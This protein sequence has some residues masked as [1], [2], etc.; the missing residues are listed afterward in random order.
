[1]PDDDAQPAA[2][3]ITGAVEDLSTESTGGDDGVTPEAASAHRRRIGLIIGAVVVTIGLVYLF[4][5]LTS[6][7]D[8]QRG[9]IIAGVEVGGL[10]PADAVTRLRAELTEL[11]DPIP[12]LSHG[13]PISLDPVASGLS[14]DIEAS[15]AA[16]GTRSAN[17]FSRVA[18]LFGGTTVEPL[19]A[20]VDEAALTARMQQIAATSDLE[21]VEGQL[22]LDGTTVRAVQPVTGEILDV[23]AAVAVISDRWTS[24]NPL[25][26]TGLTLPVTEQTVRVSA[27]AVTSSAAELSTL[28]AGPLTVAA[29]DASF[30]VPVESIATAITV[31]PD[32]A[33]GFTV[34]VDNDAIKALYRAQ[35][36]ATATPAID[37]S[38]SIVDNAPVITPGADGSAV[39]WATTDAALAAALRAPDHRLVVTYAPSRPAVTTEAVQALGITEVVSEFTTGGFAKDS[40]MNVRRAAEQLQGA[41][42]RPG[43]TFSLNGYTGV[44]NA[45]TGYVEAGIIDNGVAS[46]GIAGGVSQLATTLYNAGFFS[47][48]QDVEHKPHSFYISRYPPGRE[49]TVFT[50]DDGTSL[51]DVKFK[52]VYPTAILIQTRWT[53]SDITVT[54]W[55]TKTVE[56]ESISSDRYGFTD[57]PSRTIPFGE[58]CKATTGTQG[59]KIDVTRVIR[60]LNGTE[61]S[62]ETRTTSYNGQVKITCA[63]PPTPP[64]PPAPPIP[65]PAVPP[66]PAAGG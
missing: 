30:A 64:P 22:G 50:T 24:G 38:V 13:S 62:R 53:P 14:A 19:T 6:K 55:G 45:D 11:Q 46:R 44:R 56:V 63:P 3:T 58:T 1:M 40:G 16:V 27:A 33:D 20:T 26:V 12:M 32:D 49:A 4:D 25:A 65:D 61:L 54:F 36:E 8:L 41:I 51:I 48:M 18:A 2:D 43:E 29:G 47:G 37:A 28:L 59:F 5:W 42:V 35:V 66:P 57:A 15:V 34:T 52:N 9:T 39:D 60:D 7:D 10:T 31:T 21:P 23:P 17:P